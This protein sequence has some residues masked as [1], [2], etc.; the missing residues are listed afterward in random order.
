[1]YRFE[2]TF[3]QGGTPRNP[4]DDEVIGFAVLKNTGLDTA[5]CDTLIAEIAEIA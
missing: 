4:D 3:D 2:L 5:F 1:M